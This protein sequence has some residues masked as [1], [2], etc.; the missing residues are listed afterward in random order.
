MVY[1][2][3]WYDMVYGTVW[4]NMIYDTIYVMIYDM[5]WYMICYGIWYMI[6]Y[7]T[8]YY[9]IYL[10]T[11]IGLTPGGSSTVHI[12]TQTIHRTTQ[13]N[14]VH[15]T[16]HNIHKYIPE[17]LCVFFSRLRAEKLITGYRFD[18]VTQFRWGYRRVWWNYGINIICGNQTTSEKHLLPCHFNFITHKV[19]WE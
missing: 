15:R 19:T 3:I 8:M 4:C 6:W 14:R 13:W 10:L 9:T 18:A 12:Y 16:E 17:L 11:A 1:D 7:D 5:L 2:V